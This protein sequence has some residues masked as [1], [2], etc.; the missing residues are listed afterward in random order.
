MTHLNDLPFSTLQFYTTAPYPCSYLDGRQARSQVATPSHLINVDVYSELV[1]NGFR[2]SGI[3]TYRPYCD[4]CQACIPVRVV[5]AAFTPSRAQRRAWAR[6]APLQ[7]G[8]ATLAFLDE[9]YELYLRYQSTRHAG[10][11]MDQDSRDQYAQFLLQ[12]RVN[13]RLVE[14]R[15]PDG[16]L[17]MV[18]I[19]DVLADG[20]SSVYTFF[21][22]DVAGASYGTY[23]V[24]WQIAQAAD[25]Q[26]PYVYLGY[27]IKQSQKMAYKINF[28]PL[29]ARV[30]GAW[31]PLAGT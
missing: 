12:S 22:P 1:R 24:M 25:L 31:S 14:F 15:E 13:T 21:D 20:L 11:G 4:G 5:A 7:A 19:I 10:G 6:H 8:V 28:K 3:F 27:W 29:E 18:S 23:N 17:R 16:T 26:L 2:R 9:H 30:K